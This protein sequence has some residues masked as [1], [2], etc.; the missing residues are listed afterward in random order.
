MKIAVLGSGVI[1][2]TTAWWLAQDGHEVVVIDRQ[3]GAAQEATRAC[4]GL[5]SA[6][7]GEPWAN[8]HAPWDLLRN[9]FKD[10]APMV[11]RPA[12]DTKQWLWSLAFLRECQ[13]KRF[14]A[15]IRAMVR[16]AEYSR[17][18]LAQ[19][20][21]QLALKYDYYDSGILSFYR[22]EQS[23]DHSQ[24]MV[25]RL[26]D[27]GV[28]RRVLSAEEVIALEPTLAS[29]QHQIV[30]GDY[31]SDDESGDAYGFTTQLAQQAAQEG[32]QFLYNH[33]VVR[34]LYRQGAV[35]AVEVIDHL[36]NY[37]QIQADAFVVALGAYSPLLLEPLG[38]RCLVYPAKGYSATFTILDAE[39]APQANLTDRAQR[40]VYSRV[41][42]Q[43]RVAG[44]A[45]LSGY[46]RKLSTKRCN[47]MVKQTKELFPNGLDFDN[48]QFW[49]GLRPATPSNTPLIGRT[50]IKN[51][52]VNT[53]HGTLGWTMGAGSAR[54]LADLIANRQPEPEFPFLH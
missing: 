9:L 46:S 1:G 17:S 45:E 16:L 10:D 19:M 40:L 44:L 12:L 54:A 53:G 6:S 31:S 25:D 32:V 37:Q 41:G 21:Q 22:D 23:F 18:T 14:E 4:G 29:V 2:T 52:Y 51:L 47:M 3:A 8:P 36:G 28:E 13:P 35:T 26:R 50:H 27:L 15:N 38:I 11:F 48:V 24:D 5:L 42:N 30:G 39:Q 49:S 43:L 7:Y 33:T 20:R 34:L